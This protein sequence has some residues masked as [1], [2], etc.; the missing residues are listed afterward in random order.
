MADV[1]LLS[2]SVHCFIRSWHG[3]FRIWLHLKFGCRHWLWWLGRN[4]PASSSWPGAPMLSPAQ[5]S[6]AR[7]FNFV[8]WDARRKDC[9]TVKP[10]SIWWEQ[11]ETSCT[12][13]YRSG[14]LVNSIKYFI[15]TTYICI[16]IHC[17]QSPCHDLSPYVYAKFAFCPVTIFNTVSACH[18]LS[19]YLPSMLCW[20]PNQ[21]CKKNA[22]KNSSLFHPP[23]HLDPPGEQSTTLREDANKH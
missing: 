1:N 10:N 17:I 9:Q 19:L 12:C 21:E 18:N 7:L 2:S 15:F 13:T 6:M 22:R 23:N 20:N 4:W 5:P 14:Y 16:Y 11:S 3:F 8:T